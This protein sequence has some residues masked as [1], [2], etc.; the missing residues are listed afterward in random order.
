MIDI[1]TIIEKKNL[2]IYDLAKK[3][4]DKTIDPQDLA[5]EIIM[6][7]YDNENKIKEAHK[8]GYLDR[9]LYL[10]TINHMRDLQR[11]KKIRLEEITENIIEEEAEPHFLPTIKTK[12]INS[13]LRKLKGL[14]RIYIETWV[15]CKF[16]TS[17][18][19]RQIGICNKTF[20]KNK[21]EILEKC[22]KLSL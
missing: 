3:I 12:G 1:N 10:M 5:H 19:A 8:K 14:D 13:I 22:K 2:K 4:A 9:L 11:K 20:R 7:C 18:A 15:E 21:N 17:E 16:N 6:K